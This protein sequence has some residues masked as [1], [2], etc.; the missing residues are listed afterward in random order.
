MKQ[1]KGKAGTLKS[2]PFC[3]GKGQTWDVK[4]GTEPKGPYVFQDDMGILKKPFKGRWI[5]QCGGCLVT[6]RH[7][8]EKRMAIEAWNR[9]AK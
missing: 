5:I 1:R 2:C 6:G 8:A 4:D 7:W 3:G 9:R